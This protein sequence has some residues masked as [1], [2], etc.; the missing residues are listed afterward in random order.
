MQLSSDGGFVHNQY[1]QPPG[2]LESTIQGCTVTRP[3]KTSL[4]TQRRARE[5]IEA[6]R[7]GHTTA[8][9]P[10]AAWFV[11]AEAHWVLGERQDA[12][13]A[14]QKCS[15]LQQSRELGAL[16]AYRLAV[17][18]HVSTTA[19]AEAFKVMKSAIDMHGRSPEL[20]WLAAYTAYYSGQYL[21]SKDWALQAVQTGCYQGSCMSQGR[22]PMVTG[23]RF[24][25]PFDVLHFA[26]S[27]LGDATGAELAHQETQLANLA[28]QADP[29]G[30]VE[31]KADVSVV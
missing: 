17:L 1:V 3:A 2:L 5:S 11:L 12:Q 19:H 6:V 16:C 27:K 18:V 7:E 10:Q 13:S 25:F 8:D 14:W 15:K 30:M 9:M 24:G 23:A 20:C 21:Q 22:I 28:S 26:L 29:S 4:W 31:M